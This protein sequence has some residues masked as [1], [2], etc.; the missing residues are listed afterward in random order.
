MWV[1]LGFDRPSLL[2]RNDGQLLAGSVACKYNQTQSSN[3]KHWLETDFP[4][5]SLAATQPHPGKPAFSRQP[6]LN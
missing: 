1:W 2:K 6:S 5:S 4:S 3:N